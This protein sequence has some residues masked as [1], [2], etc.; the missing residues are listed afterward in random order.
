MVTAVSV[1][2][3]MLDIIFL[4]EHRDIILLGQRLSKH[5]DIIHI[6][7]DHTYAGHIEQIILNILQRETQ[8]LAVQLTHDA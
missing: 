4:F 3:R 1:G 5:I 6:R 7:T 2:L 8:I